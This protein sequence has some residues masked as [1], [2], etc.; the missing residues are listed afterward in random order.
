MGNLPIPPEYLVPTL[1]LLL[2]AYNCATHIGCTPDRY[3]IEAKA[4][5]SIGTPQAV[6]R[7]LCDVG[8]VRHL[9]E[10]TPSGAK[11]RE[12]EGS[13]DDSFSEK[14]WFVLTD[15]GS[16]FAQ[17]VLSVSQAIN[18]PASKSQK[19]NSDLVD[20]ESS[21]G[22][23]P[24]WDDQ[25]GKL[26][27]NGVVIKQLNSRATHQ[28]LILQALQEM[29]WPPSIDDPLPRGPE[30][31]RTLHLRSAIRGLSAN[32]NPCSL[33]FSS[34]GSK[35]QWDLIAV[36]GHPIIAEDDSRVS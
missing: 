36:N 34:S 27:F 20:G 24:H 1:R 21:N 18:D 7:W 25:S 30:R 11:R 14:S 31:D 5:W 29:G 3:A 23:T 26:W 19:D 22:H 28:R 13:P 16:P 33:L 6:L 35:I 8:H 15:E 10:T 17:G 4:F 32:Q 9:A 12:L 2:E